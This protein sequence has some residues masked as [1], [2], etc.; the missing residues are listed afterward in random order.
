LILD[1]NRKYYAQVGNT[2][3][4]FGD[5]DNDVGPHNYLTLDLETL[6][7]SPPLLD[8]LELFD[9]MPTVVATRRDELFIFGGVFARNQTGIIQMNTTTQESRFIHIEGFPEYIGDNLTYFMAPPTSVYVE[10]QNR[11]YFFGGITYFLAFLPNI[12]YIDLNDIPDF[13]L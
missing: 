12:W 8:E 6:E 1:T 10:S 3:F 7:S 2:A 11:I 4:I 5:T 9:V 13:V